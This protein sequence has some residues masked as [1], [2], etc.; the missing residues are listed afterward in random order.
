[1]KLVLTTFIFALLLSSCNR[2]LYVPNALNMPLLAKKND[3]NFNISSRVVAPANLEGQLGY[4]PLNH[5][6]VVANAAALGY[7]SSF[8]RLNHRFVELGAG[9]FTSFLEGYRQPNMIRA[10]LIGGYGIGSAI[11]EKSSSAIDKS[12]GSYNRKFLQPAVGIKTD[13]LEFSFGV[14]LSE[15]NF[16]HYNDYSNDILVGSDIYNFATIEPIM[17]IAV[18]HKGVKMAVQFG[19]ISNAGGVADFEAATDEDWVRTQFF[20]SLSFSNWPDKKPAASPSISLRKAT[21]ADALGPALLVKLSSPNFKICVKRMGQMD[22]DTISIGYNGSPLAENIG[23]ASS[24]P[25]FELKAL[26]NLEN[27][28]VLLGVS[29]GNYEYIKMQ[30]TVTT[31]D[32]L[33]KFQFRL[34]AGKT[35]EIVFSLE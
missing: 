19:R 16:D 8:S 3:Y 29:E 15:V 18:G 14:R 2:T 25:C 17:R 21:P 34:E 7:N 5:L 27:R 23:L 12:E 13:F 31:G 22:V 6:V 1:M 20:G 32:S 24:K 33:R 10:E 28:M 11:F 9:V 4:A 26:P 30:V 35:N